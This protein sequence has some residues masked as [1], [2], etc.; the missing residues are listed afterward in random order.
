M[1]QITISNMSYQYSSYYNPIFEKVNLVLDTNWKSGLI[2]RNGRGRT[3]LLK[4]LMGVLEPDSRY[5]KL[6]GGIDYFPYENVTG[7]TK[8]IDIIKENIGGL[9]TMEIVIDE[10]INSNNQGLFDEYNTILDKYT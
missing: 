4:L 5:I 9:R 6:P 10:I 7:Y 3:T 1:S 8:V 2:G